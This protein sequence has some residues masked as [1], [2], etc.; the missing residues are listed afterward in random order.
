MRHPPY[1]IYKS[2]AAVDGSGNVEIH[3]LIGPVRSVKSAQFHCITRIAEIYE[4][5]AFDRPAILYVQTGN[6][7]FC[8]HILSYK[9]L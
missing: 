8:E 2:R 1:E 6:Y 7:P 3:Q 5:D 4:I 9:T